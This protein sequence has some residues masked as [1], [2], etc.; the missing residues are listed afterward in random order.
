[1]KQIFETLIISLSFVFVSWLVIIA[2]V[3]FEVGINGKDYRLSIGG[4]SKQEKYADFINSMYWSNGMWDMDLLFTNSELENVKPEV[5]E[6]FIRTMFP[7]IVSCNAYQYGFLIH[8][9]LKPCE[10][11]YRP[12][13]TYLE[14]PNLQTEYTVIGRKSF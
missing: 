8:A 10:Y 12:V 7:L 14:K 4:A 1:M 11:P 13:Y 6:D 3:K 2:G 5:F 9:E